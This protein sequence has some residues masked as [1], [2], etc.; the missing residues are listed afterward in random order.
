M[1]KINTQESLEIAVAEAVRLKLQRSSLVS[2][3]EAEKTAIEKKH[4]AVLS[5]A[6]KEIS[7]LE[8]QIMAYCVANRALLFPAKKSLETRTAVVGFEFTPWRVDKPKRITWDNILVRLQHLPWA[9]RFLRPAKETVNKELLLEN[10]ETL[11]PE[12]LDVIGIRFDR[13]EIFFLR[14]KADMAEPTTI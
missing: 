14:P 5:A 4:A 1:L 10:R 12:Q 11:T 9:A 3:I 8:S 7:G 13:D 2:K 6:E